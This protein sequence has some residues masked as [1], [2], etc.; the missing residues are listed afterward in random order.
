MGL[1]DFQQVWGLD[2]ISEIPGFGWE[3]LLGDF[4]DEG[5]ETFE[6]GRGGGGV[7]LGVEKAAVDDGCLLGL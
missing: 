5:G 3:L 1:R 6:A 2:K 7:V 4:E